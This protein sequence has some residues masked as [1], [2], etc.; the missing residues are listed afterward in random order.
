MR[1][2]RVTWQNSGKSQETRL[3]RLTPGCWSEFIDQPINLYTVY[4][5]LLNLRPIVSHHIVNVLQWKSFLMIEFRRSRG[6]VSSPVRASVKTGHHPGR[7]TLLLSH[8]CPRSHLG[9][10]SLYCRSRLSMKSH[11]S[12]WHLALHPHFF[13][14]KVDFHIPYTVEPGETFLF[15]SL[16]ISFCLQLPG[17]HKF[18]CLSWLFLMN[19]SI[20]IPLN[21]H[22]NNES[23]S[24]M[25]IV[26][27]PSRPKTEENTSILCLRVW[28]VIGLFMVIDITNK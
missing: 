11:L 6:R 1:G 26:C 9:S 13:L 27:R 20:F 2:D 21:F 24:T 3:Q 7:G 8:P 12:L 22:S 14:H 23:I 15:V 17:W 28:E 25:S 10:N 19:V 5:K 18:F 4:P 16:G